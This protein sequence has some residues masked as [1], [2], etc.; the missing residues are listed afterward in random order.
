V[1]V[2]APPGRTSRRDWDIAAE[3]GLGTLRGLPVFR[4]RHPRVD[5][6]DSESTPRTIA[7]YDARKTYLFMAFC[8]CSS[9]FSGVFWRRRYGS[10]RE[11]DRRGGR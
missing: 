9:L 6:V 5:S 11:L 1:T 8:L 10:E 4:P 7:K 3:V 2:I